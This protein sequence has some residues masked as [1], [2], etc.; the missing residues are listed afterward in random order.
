MAGH[1]DPIAGNP[2]LI[3]REKSNKIPAD[4]T[5]RMEQQGD[6]ACPKTAVTL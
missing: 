1:V 4:M 2:V 6:V 3:D 5:R